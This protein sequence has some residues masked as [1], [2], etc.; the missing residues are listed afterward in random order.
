MRATAKERFV[1]IAPLKI[2]QVSQLVKGMEVSEALSVLRFS[3]KGGAHVLYKL[4]TAAQANAYQEG[5]SR[6]SELF[7]RN[8]LV[9]QGPDYK[10]IRPRAR[11]SRDIIRKRTSH[12]TV[13]VDD[14]QEED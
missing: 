11:G 5:G 10:R 9:D 12:V 2:R 3:Q 14:G 4:V 7:V 8:T 1:R 13:V 6:S